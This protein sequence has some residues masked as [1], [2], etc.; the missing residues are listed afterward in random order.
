MTTMQTVPL[1][2]SSRS[3]PSRLRTP[4]PG[5]AQHDGQG[6]RHR[7]HQVNP[8]FA[9]SR[10]SLRLVEY[11]TAAHLCACGCGTKVVALLGPDDWVLIFDGTVTQRPSGGNGQVPCRSHYIRHDRIDWLPRISAAATRA[12]VARDRAA[13]DPPAR[14]VVVRK[15]W[16]RRVRDRIPDQLNR[17]FSAI[18]SQPSRHSGRND[19]AF[20]RCCG[21]GH[22]R[23]SRA[24]PPL[25]PDQ[26]GRPDARREP[27]RSKEFSG[28]K[29]D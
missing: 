7:L 10:D 20:A 28:S 26:L 2:T 29:R 25:A 1:S 18:A 9:G 6:T 27:R 11:Q 24:Q 21:R 17:T 4:T 15:S 5:K 19:T 23:F 13:H 3:K 14:A 22:R 8:S 12:A 16:R